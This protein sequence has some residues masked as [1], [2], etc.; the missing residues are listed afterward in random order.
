MLFKLG[1]LI[2]KP[3][4]TNLMGWKANNSQAPFAVA[5]VIRQ[6]RRGAE[7]GIQGY[8]ETG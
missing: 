1:M 5:Q 3:E 2:F 8:E 4:R 7:N 6:G